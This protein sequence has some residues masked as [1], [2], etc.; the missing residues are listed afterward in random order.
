VD[1]IINTMINLEREP[2]TTESEVWISATSIGTI[3]RRIRS[4]TWERKTGE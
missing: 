4:G 2:A 3:P 1:G